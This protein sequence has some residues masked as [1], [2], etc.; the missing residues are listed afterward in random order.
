MG[1]RR[2]WIVVVAL[3]V[4]TGALAGDHKAEMCVAF[5][6]ANAEGSEIRIYGFQTG[7]AWTP[8]HDHPWF[9]LVADAAVHFIGGETEGPVE[10]D[11]TQVTLAG[12]FRLT[13]PGHDHHPV[14]PYGQFKMGVVDRVG[15]IHPSDTAF[16]FVASAGLDW[17]WG[18]RGW[19][20][21][22]QVDYVWK[23]GDISGS[24]QFS[25]GF[26]RRFTYESESHPLPSP[27]PDPPKP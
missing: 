9:G 3:F 16:A 19:A 10:Q 17:T 14:M 8:S 1:L 25:I 24:W 13:L 2:F 23:A 15:G 20:P 4:P 6:K 22:F 7:G 21:R 11:V 26:V 5:S 12:G 18:G 27:R